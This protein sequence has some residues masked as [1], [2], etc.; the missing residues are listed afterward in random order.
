MKPA[1]SLKRGVL[2]FWSGGVKWDGGV[3]LL[4]VKEYGVGGGSKYG[5]MAK[6]L[7]QS[8][9][10]FHVAILFSALFCMFEIFHNFNKN[11]FKTTSVKQGGDG[12]GPDQL[13]KLTQSNSKWKRQC[14]QQRA[15]VDEE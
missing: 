6:W 8:W 4:C 3:E 12:S 15:G 13:G 14:A 7:N 10:V 2:A 9:S 1:V 11:S 5:K